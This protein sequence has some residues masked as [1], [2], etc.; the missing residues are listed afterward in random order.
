MG[1][2]RNAPWLKDKTGGSAESSF[3]ETDALVLNENDAAEVAAAETES[4]PVQKKQ[5]KEKKLK[6]ESE[7]DR[8]P[9]PAPAPIP[10]EQVKGKKAYDWKNPEEQR[11]MTAE[12]ATGECACSHACL[13]MSVLPPMCPRLYI[14]SPLSTA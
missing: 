4:T 3:E 5:K 8:E 2:K 9:E 14:T 6:N 12:E 1:K 7:A 11:I 10:D 13:C